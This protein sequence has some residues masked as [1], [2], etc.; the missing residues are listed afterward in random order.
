M[1]RSCKSWNKP[2]WIHG[3]SYV[4]SSLLLGAEVQCRLQFWRSYSTLVLGM[5]FVNPVGYPVYTSVSWLQ[6]PIL[7]LLA[8]VGNISHVGNPNT[9]F[10]WSISNVFRTTP[11]PW[12][13]KLTA[14]PLSQ[15]PFESRRCN[16]ESGTAVCLVC[17]GF[18]PFRFQRC[19]LQPDKSG[20]CGLCGFHNKTSGF[21]QNMWIWP[22]STRI[23]S[24]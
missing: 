9:H 2:S 5:F 15:G 8:S 4:H 11:F 6:Y 22:A 23:L 24:R 20:L 16:P 19:G 17:G 12:V 3:S 10:S 18:D 7:L 14:G 21:S 1:Y 13:R